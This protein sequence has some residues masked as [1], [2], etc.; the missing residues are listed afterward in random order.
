MK[1]T[2]LAAPCPK[3]RRRFVRVISGGQTGVDQIALQT[4]KY[5]DLQTGGWAVAGFMTN[6]WHMKKLETTYGMREMPKAATLSQA[7]VL[8]SQRNV[9]D[10]NGVLAFRGHASPGTD[11]TIGYALSKRWDVPQSSSSSSFS[12]GPAPIGTYRPC[13]VVDTNTCNEDDVVQ[14]I[15]KFICT[16]NIS[17]LNV[18]GHR[19][20]TTTA[21]RTYI[22]RVERILLKVFRQC[23]RLDQDIAAALDAPDIWASDVNGP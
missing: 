1:Q 23:Q 12:T 4:A 6:A 16:H 17:I 15:G 3:R 2:T 13:F 14:Q 18:A 10:A 21:Y 20:D 7:Y 9:D 5:C 8:R 22:Q 19:E 11:K